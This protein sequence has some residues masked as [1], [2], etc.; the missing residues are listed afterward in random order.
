VLNSNNRF[1]VVGVSIRNQ[2]AT[3][4]TYGGVPLTLAGTRDGSSSLRVEMWTLTNPPVG[5]ANVTVSLTGSANVVGGAVSMA[6]ISASSPVAGFSANDDSGSSTASVGGLLGS[7]Q[8][9]W[10]NTLAVRLTTDPDDVTASPQSPQVQHWNN[11]SGTN[12]GDVLGGGSSK[13]GN[14][15]L[16]SVSWDLSATGSDARPWVLG[17]LILNPTPAC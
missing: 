15:L 2:Q 6:G 10:L 12:N 14:L 1:L 4:V 5:T 8:Q 17:V 7:S 9:L 16:P 11:R 13:Y 3:S